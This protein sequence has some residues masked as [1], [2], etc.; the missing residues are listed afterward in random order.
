VQAVLSQDPGGITDL[1][2]LTPSQ[3]RHIALEIAWN[4]HIAPLPSP[5]PDLETLYTTDAPGFDSKAHQLFEAALLK[6]SA[7]RDAK[8]QLLA[9]YIYSMVAALI[10]EQKSSDAVR[11]GLRFP[12]QPGVVTPSGKVHESDV[13]LRN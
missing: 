1:R 9:A 5:S 8:A 12:I 10:C 7:E 3:C 11:A 2:T 4:R 13:V 6:Y